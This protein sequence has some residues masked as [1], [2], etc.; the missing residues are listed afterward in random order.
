MMKKV[1]G[2]KRLLSFLLL[3]II[4][5][6]AIFPYRQVIQDGK[7]HEVRIQVQD[8]STDLDVGKAD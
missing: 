5:V 2:I 7:F 6:S 8:K 4:S 1:Y 3:G